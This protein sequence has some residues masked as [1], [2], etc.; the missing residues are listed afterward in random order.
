[1]PETA[2]NWRKDAAPQPIS[3]KESS[4]HAIEGGVEV[5][6]PN[7]APTVY[8]PLTSAQAKPAIALA[9]AVTN[10]PTPASPVLDGKPNGIYVVQMSRR[11]AAQLGSAMSR[12]ASQATEVKDVAGF[13]ISATQQA[14]SGGLQP[15]DKHEILR[16]A[17]NGAVDRAEAP[18]TNPSLREQIASNLALATGVGG[19]DPAQSADRSKMPTTQPIVAPADDRFGLAA[20]ISTTQPVGE[21]VSPTTALADEPVNVVILIEANPP[22]AASTPSTQPAGVAAQPVPSATTQSTENAK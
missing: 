11:Q 21:K 2:A 6:D 20:N 17:G 14:P 13:G 22:V 10:H 16:V 4:K 8:P 15:T 3:G 1:L 19:S 7:E 18:T 9:D 5:L 12:D